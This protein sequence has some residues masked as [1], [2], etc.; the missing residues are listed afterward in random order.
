MSVTCAILDKDGKRLTGIVTDICF[1]FMYSLKRAC[2]CFNTSEDI[3]RKGH[4]LEYYPDDASLSPDVV[5]E[6]LNILR[7][8][9]IGKV[10]EGTDAVYDSGMQFTVRGDL[11]IHSGQAI[12]GAME[13]IRNVVTHPSFVK[14]VTQLV[15]AGVSPEV[16]L[17]LPRFFRVKG[18]GINI[19]TADT[20]CA[21]S[22][23][24]LVNGEKLFRDKNIIQKNTKFGAWIYTH[25][26][27]GV[28]ELYKGDEVIP[29]STTYYRY[30]RQS[31]SL[32]FNAANQEAM[33][34]SLDHNALLSNTKLLAEV[35]KLEDMPFAKL[36]QACK[37]YQRTQS[38]N[39]R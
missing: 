25:D 10:L 26:F 12:I 38:L 27:V 18:H 37:L 36:V 31:S 19:P 20:T 33:T 14:V 39:V 16:A 6:Y 24:F 7:S 32:S 21:A 4:F 15:Q 17:F 3:I 9:G 28:F 23:Y 1:G 11:T 8:I 30:F 5:Q 34:P 22:H 29:M 2:E 35:Y 13:L